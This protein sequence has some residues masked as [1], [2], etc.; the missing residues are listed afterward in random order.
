MSQKQLVIDAL[1]IEQTSELEEMKEQLEDARHENKL[2][3]LRLH[4]LTHAYEKEMENVGRTR[5]E[6]PLQVQG[7][8]YTSF[9][10]FCPRT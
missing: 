10:V 9:T 8:V 3:K 7:G 2:L 4:S 5:S 1:K 6:P